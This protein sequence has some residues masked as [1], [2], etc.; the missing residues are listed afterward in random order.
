MF[1][2]DTNTIIY[3][4]KGQGRVED[5]LSARNPEELALP[6]VVLYEL[7]L[8]AEKSAN[9]NRRMQQLQRLSAIVRCLAFDKTE[10]EHAASIR[11]DLERRG[12]TIGPIDVLI[13]ATARACNATLVT[14]N[15]DEF[16]RVPDL[17]LVDW[18]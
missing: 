12:G 5:N 4:F 1:V 14:H 6:S 8:G 11:A 3:W 17:R 16:K 9:P 18:Y 2:L 7:R 15:L 13:A 10:A